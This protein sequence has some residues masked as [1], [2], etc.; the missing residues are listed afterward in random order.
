MFSSTLVSRKEVCGKKTHSETNH[1]IDSA[2]KGS[3]FSWKERF[4]NCFTFAGF[5]THSYFVSSY[6]S[7]LKQ[8]ES[9]SVLFRLNLLRQGTIRTGCERKVFHFFRIYCAR[10]RVLLGGGGFMVRKRFVSCL[11]FVLFRTSSGIH[12]DRRFLLKFIRACRNKEVWEALE[13]FWGSGEAFA[14]SQKVAYR[15]CC[16]LLFITV[17]IFFLRIHSRGFMNF[18]VF[19]VVRIC[20]GIWG[21]FA[22]A[23]I[24]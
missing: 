8:V 2:R 7:F 14:D 16:K 20:A 11:F 3:I 18:C 9:I 6:L 19:F 15:T 12:E 10:F 5:P 1:A 23:Y 24:Y 4:T 21:R 17:G 13:E 22:S